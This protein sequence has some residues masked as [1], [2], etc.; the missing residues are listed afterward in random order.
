[1]PE[2]KK[3][4]SYSL[5]IIAKDR[6]RIEELEKTLNSMNK[7]SVA[8]SELEDYI[9]DL[10]SIT[11]DFLFNISNNLESKGIER[12]SEITA[13]IVDELIILSPPS[14]EYNCHGWSLGTLIN[15]PFFSTK[16]KFLQEALLYRQ[17]Q[18]FQIHT[19][20]TTYTFF[21][22]PESLLVENTTSTKQE[23]SIAIYS[24]KDKTITHTAR[25]LEPV[26][27]ML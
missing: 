25:Y 17:Q 5:P 7:R 26:F 8:Y 21:S 23:G 12:A 24:D 4:A 1:M 10:K 27:M 18:D 20:S 2:F 22:I 11:K 9:A 13:D 15:V 14:A 3:F 16:E 6:H 19:D